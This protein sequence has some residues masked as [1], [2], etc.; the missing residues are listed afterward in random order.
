MAL[1]QRGM[2]LDT[3]SCGHCNR[4]NEYIDHILTRFSFVNTTREWIFKWCDIEN[5][6]FNNVSELLKFTATWGRCL[7]K[8]KLLT[9]ICYRMLWLTWKTRND[10]MFKQRTTSPTLVADN[11]MSLGFVWLKHRY[12]RVKRN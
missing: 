10:R 8:R 5:M 4:E 6:S 2:N 1:L 7:K 3:I 11:I 9:V 12:G